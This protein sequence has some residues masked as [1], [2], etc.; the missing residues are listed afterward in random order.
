[1]RNPCVA[2]GTTS[3]LGIAALTPTYGFSPY[4]TGFVGWGER[5]DAQHPRLQ[6]RTTD[7]KPVR[8]NT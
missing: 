8:N 1:M 3:S 2:A 7:M 6:N 4:A 5:S